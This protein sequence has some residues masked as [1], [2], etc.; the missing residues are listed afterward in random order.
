MRAPSI[1]GCQPA[2]TAADDGDPLPLAVEIAF[3]NL[4]D[5]EDRSRSCLQVDAV[6]TLDD[7]SESGRRTDLHASFVCL[8]N[9]RPCAAVCPRF[10][11]WLNNSGCASRYRLSVSLTACRKAAPNDWND[12]ARL[13]GTKPL[14][15]ARPQTAKHGNRPPSWSV[16]DLPN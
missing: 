12:A 9:P 5:Y 11:Q 10:A 1:C 13:G 16:G 4:D 15:P 2:N 14:I 8:S 7:L 3:A 6:E